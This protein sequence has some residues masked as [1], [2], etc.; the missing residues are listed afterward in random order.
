MNK[1]VVGIDDEIVIPGIGLAD[2]IAVRL[3]DGTVLL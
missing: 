1:N 2:G 3:N